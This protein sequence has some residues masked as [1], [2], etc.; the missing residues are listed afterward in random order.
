MMVT[1]ADG[2]GDVPVLALLLEFMR[3]EALFLV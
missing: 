3:N 1:G 2:F